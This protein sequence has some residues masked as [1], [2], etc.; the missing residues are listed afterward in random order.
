M[1][2]MA[3]RSEGQDK[4]APGQLAVLQ[5]FVNTQYGHKPRRLHNEVT[6]PEQLR[7]WL[8]EHHLLA[9]NQP[10]TEGDF[11]RVLQAREAVRSF[12]RMNT[13]PESAPAQV[14][15]LNNL[16]GNAPLTVRFQQDGL[17][18][19]QQDIDGVDGVIAQIVG[20]V[21]TAMIDGS[22]G[23]LKACRNE[24]CQ[25][26]FYDTSKNHSG[27]W[28]SMT[29][30]GSRFKAHVYRQRHGVHAQESPI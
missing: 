25:K 10:V 27:S 13:D 4:T 1:N 2:N 7:A 24:R 26:A 14:E 19:L 29:S 17:P 3:T 8:V 11:R 9:E 23:R 18:T 22:W 6:N 12:L 20:I 30:C 16:A 21:F 28:C 5:A 15:L